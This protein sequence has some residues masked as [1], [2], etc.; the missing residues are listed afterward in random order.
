MC[1]PSTSLSP[2]PFVPIFPLD[3]A[4]HLKQIASLVSTHPLALLPLST[5]PRKLPEG[6][7]LLMTTPVSPW[8]HCA[9]LKVRIFFTADANGEILDTLKNSRKGSAQGTL[10]STLWG[11]LSAEETEEGL[12]NS[13][14]GLKIG[15]SV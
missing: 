3:Q 12:R 14:L 9:I 13:P 4:P 8:T 11:L 10:Q 6:M 7:S 15:V 1:L 2:S 5:L